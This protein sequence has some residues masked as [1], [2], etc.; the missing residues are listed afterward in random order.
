MKRN[1]IEPSSTRDDE[2]LARHADLIARAAPGP[3]LELGCGDGRDTRWLVAHHPFVI[4]TDRTD[5]EDCR[6]RA[7]EATLVRLDHGKPLPFRPG[8]FPLVVASLSLHYF[9]WEQTQ[10][11]VAD[12]RDSL[13]AGGHLL[14]RLNSIADV[15]F[16][17]RGHPEIARH[18]YRVK[19]RPKRF[20][21]AADLG[22]LFA[23]GWTELLRD[24]RTIDRYGR[25]KVAWE[26][27][28]RR[29]EVGS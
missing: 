13:V 19:G 5:L 22:A 26:L 12:V 28:L 23:H 3:L 1:A 20:F 14:C 18:Y 8:T 24:E 10:R 27:V 15:R 11:I 17:A 4:A 16:G 25:P 21:D 2:W 6:R 7:P 29:Q 9:D